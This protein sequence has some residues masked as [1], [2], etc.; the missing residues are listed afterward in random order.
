MVAAKAR[1]A[2]LV[3]HI[4]NDHERDR[5]H[6]IVPKAHELSD[7]LAE[8]TMDLD[9]LLPLVVV[10]AGRDSLRLPRHVEEHEHDHARGIVAEGPRTSRCTRRRSH[11]P[12]RSAASCGYRGRSE[13]L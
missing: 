10:A 5:A 4:I 8:E 3:P 9:G 1:D 11:G 7:A 6:E 13:Q 2:L 12:A